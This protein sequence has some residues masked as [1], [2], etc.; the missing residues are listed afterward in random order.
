MDEVALGSDGG[1][2]LKRCSGCRAMQAAP[3]QLHST[4][5]PLEPLEVPTKTRDGR[6]PEPPTDSQGPAKWG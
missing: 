5:P 3:R 4:G 6:A 2:R 1:G